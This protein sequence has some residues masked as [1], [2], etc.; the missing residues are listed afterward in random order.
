MYGGFLQTQTLSFCV[1]MQ[2]HGNAVPLAVADALAP[3]GVTIDSLPLHGEV[4]HQLLR[5]DVSWR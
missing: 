1:A 5:G 2:L 4:V 3:A